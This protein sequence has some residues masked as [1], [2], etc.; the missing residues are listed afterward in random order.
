MRTFS[1]VVFICNICF[2]AAAVIRVID[3]GLKK[4]GSGEALIPLPFLVAT[5]A[6]LG[7]FVSFTL[8]VAFAISFA[9]KKFSK[10]IIVTNPFIVY[11]NLLMLPVEIWYFFIWKT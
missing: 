11:F 1:K 4:N 2:I 10:K 9:V 6:V 8:D 5:I 7:T 3:M